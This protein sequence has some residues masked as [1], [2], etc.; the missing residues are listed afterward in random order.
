MPRFDL[1]IQAMPEEEQRAS[2]KVME[3]G[4]NPPVA[5]KGFQ[6]LID[7]WARIFLTRKGS[8]PTNL[9]RGTVFTN[10]IGS[11]TTLADA[12]DVV[13]VA[14]DSCNDQVAALQRADSTYAANER[15]ASAQLIRY[16]TDDAGPRFDAYVEIRNQAGERIQVLLPDLTKRGSL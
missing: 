12:E 9:D 6:M 1:H 14:I 16:I 2:F 11:N 8:D 10:L 7:I 15:L 3:F 13:R 5:V 4:F